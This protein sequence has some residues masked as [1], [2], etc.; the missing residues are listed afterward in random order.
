[1]S[2][3]PKIQN[4]PEKEKDVEFHLK[5]S[6]RPPG[7]ATVD[8]N[9][10]LQQLGG[11]WKR[12]ESEATEKTETFIAPESSIGE[13]HDEF[14]PLAGNNINWDALIEMHG[15]SNQGADAGAFQVYDTN[16]ELSFPTSIWNF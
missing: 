9:E 4:V 5:T 10:F 15:I 3:K 13:V 11:Y 8:L 2:D 7:E 14:G 16:E 1:M 12:R 6:R